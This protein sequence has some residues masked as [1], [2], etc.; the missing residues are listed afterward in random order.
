M[1]GRVAV[2]LRSNNH[3]SSLSPR[4]PA[5]TSLRHR[6]KRSATSLQKAIKS[7]PFPPHLSIDHSPLPPP[8]RLPLA[9][10]VCPHHH[11]QHPATDEG[12]LSSMKAGTVSLL[13][14]PYHLPLI[15]FQLHHS[16]SWIPVLLHTGAVADCVFSSGPRLLKRACH[17]LPRLPATLPNTLPETLASMA[18]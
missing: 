4:S 13:C 11:P 14:S 2:S 1:T 6:A 9:V 8:A 15:P 10:R 18:V 17:S 5:L 12:A 7:G 3:T 16:S